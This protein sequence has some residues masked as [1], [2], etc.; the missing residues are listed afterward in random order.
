M[1]NLF[2]QVNVVDREMEVKDVIENYTNLE[3]ECENAK[4]PISIELQVCITVL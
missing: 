3:K 4:Q 2:I 1:R